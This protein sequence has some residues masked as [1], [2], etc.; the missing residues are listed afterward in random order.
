MKNNKSKQ[1]KQKKKKKLTTQQHHVQDKNID[2]LDGY[3]SGNLPPELGRF[4]SRL[5]AMDLHSNRLNWPIPPDLGSNAKLRV[6]SLA[7]N[8]FSETPPPELGNIAGLA[9]RALYKNKLPGPI[10]IELGK[11]GLVLDMSLQDNE[12]SGSIP[13]TLGNLSKL[14]VL[15]LAQHVLSAF[16]PSSLTVLPCNTTAD[17]SY[18]GLLR[19]VPAGL[20][21]FGLCQEVAYFDGARCSRCGA[22]SWSWAGCCTD[23]KCQC[24][25][26]QADESYKVTY[27]VDVHGASFKK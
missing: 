8:R 25:P 6:L 9:V 1:D 19:P 5:A 20:E 15:R 12:L 13:E 10:A 18:N 21:K 4:S 3:L 7:S 26:L 2:W 17:F 22:L 23:V 27:V 24:P 14:P 11:M 16:I